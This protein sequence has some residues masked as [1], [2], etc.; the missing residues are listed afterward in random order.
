MTT[1][2]DSTAR[3]TRTTDVEINQ[4][5]SFAVRLFVG[6]ESR[7]SPQGHSAKVTLGMWVTLSHGPL[8]WVCC[9]SGKNRAGGG[10][11]IT[12]GI[13]RTGERD[14]VKDARNG[15]RDIV[16]MSALVRGRHSSKDKKAVCVKL[17]CVQQQQVNRR[18]RL[19]SKGLSF[20]LYR[21]R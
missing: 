15:P 17:R 9:T 10:G 5:S 20:S 3:D 6:F 1:S 19:L 18:V 13:R 14:E 21:L 11:R 12:L 7:P 2:I 4:A 16:R 8:T